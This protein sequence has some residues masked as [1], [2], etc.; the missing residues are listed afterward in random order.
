M[1]GTTVEE[2]KIRDEF[3][4]KKSG[5]IYLSAKFGAKI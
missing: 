1:D 4:M 5:G 3:E 2:V